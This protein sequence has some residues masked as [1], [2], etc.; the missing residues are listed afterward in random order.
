MKL[1]T[2]QTM[3]ALKELINKEVLCC[4]KKY[5]N[6]EKV[7]YA[8]NFIVSNMKKVIPS[9]ENDMY[10]MWAWVKCHN[11]IC[12]PK[13]K[14]ENNNTIVKIT[15]NKPDNEVFVT[16]FALYSFVLNNIYIPKDKN[17]KQNFDKLLLK[18][19]IN[20]DDLRAFVRKDKYP[21][22]RTDKNYLS[23]CEKIYNSFDKIITDNGDILQGCVWDIKLCDVEKIEII[24]DK[25]YIYG[26]LNYVR[27]N[28]QRFDWINDYYKKLK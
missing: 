28:G 2:F 7:G 21:C 24:N 15:F 27:A 26:S 1:V 22:H 6:F 13:V 11:S 3:D 23:V 5:I 10:P 9:P 8:Y 14:K 4:D 16:D 18:Y 25:D 12:P 20:T 17:D 19:N